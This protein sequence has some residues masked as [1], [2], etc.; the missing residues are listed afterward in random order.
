M[1]IEKLPSGKYRAVVRHAGEKR[2]SEAVL[3][4]AEAKMLEARLKLSMGGTTSPRERRTV[5]DVVA[6]Y[7]ADSAS[8]LSPGSID[9]YRKG[10]AALPDA[11]RNRLVTEVTPLVLDSL[12]AEL[13]DEGAS[14]H[15]TQKVHRLLSAA[16]NRAVRYGWMTANPCM[17]ATKPR[18]SSDEIDPPSAEWVRKLIAAAEAVNV[19]LSVCLRFAAATGA[20]RG[21]VVALKWVDFSDTR[22]TIRR[23]LVESEGR[24]VE[25]RTKTGTKGHRT[26]AV[27]ADTLAAV[28]GLR[29]RQQ[30]AA[31]EHGLPEP[32]YVFSHDAGLSPWRPAYLSLAFGRLS[33]RESRLHDLR[34]Y[35]ATQLLAAGVPVT[36]VSKR[37]GHSSSAVTLTTYAH[38]L[39]EQ[40]REAADVI[41]RLLA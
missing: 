8:R 37:L 11:F 35:H 1:S 22:V 3:T 23:S 24:L 29:E 13:R 20:R 19:D 21:E 34:H 15:K 4:A 39:P 2:S 6:G 33:R 12:Y 38:W 18:V 40:D 7:I 41:A 17:Q 36:T 25:R 9:F 31:E 16:F 5:G 28:A 14:D 26:I 30:V 32:E 27:D 10:L